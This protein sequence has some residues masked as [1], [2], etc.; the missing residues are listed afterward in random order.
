M[1]FKNCYEKVYVFPNTYL[2]FKCIFFNV[3]ND[4]KLLGFIS[5]IA[6]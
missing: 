5:N 3:K 4:Y 1:A 2:E 6:A